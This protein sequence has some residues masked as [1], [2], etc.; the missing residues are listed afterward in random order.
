MKNFLQSF[1]KKGFV[2]GDPILNKDELNK[3]RNSLDI[4]FS[5]NNNYSGVGLE[6]HQFENKT[7]AKKIIEI[8]LSK[9]INAVIKEF[10]KKFSEPLSILPSIEVHKNY[11]NNLYKTLGWHRDCGGEMN[12]DYCNT[13]LR[14]EKYFF[15]KIGIYLQENTEYGGCID[16]IKNSH[17]NFSQ[18]KIIFRKIKSFPLKLVKIFHKYFTKIYIKISEKFF[19]KLINAKRLTPKESSPVFFDSRLIH[20]GTPVSRNLISNVVFTKNNQIKLEKNYT[21]YVIYSH[22]GNS[23]SLDSYFYDRLKRKNNSDEITAWLKQVDIIKKIDRNF[24]EKIELV[25]NPI[26]KKYQK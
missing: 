13:K 14:D 25:L 4:E 22:F 20:R 17:K 26:K 18:F 21:K 12:Y 11:H 19:M 10:E 8:L 3:L 24:A 1:Q 15:S 16:I 6:I 5:N 9:E 7:L 2:Y 23:F